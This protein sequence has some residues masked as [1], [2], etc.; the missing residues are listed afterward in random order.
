[1]DGIEFVN[2]FLTQDTRWHAW[3]SSFS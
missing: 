1:M 3:I 2:E